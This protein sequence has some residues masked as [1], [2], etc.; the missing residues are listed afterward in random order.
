MRSV[1]TDVIIS[2]SCAFQKRGG[3]FHVG[4]VNTV[5]KIERP[6]EW[7]IAARRNHGRA[8]KA[9]NRDMPPQV[10]RTQ[11]LHQGSPMCKEHCSQGAG[12]AQPL[13]LL[14]KGWGWGA[15]QKAM[16]VL[17]WIP[18]SLGGSCSVLKIPTTSRLNQAS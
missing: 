7:A 8:Q 15:G 3:T 6:R 10:V 13:R 1:Q 4:S 9:G 2:L 12:P 11:N 14:D 18:V 16:G 5:I 17:S